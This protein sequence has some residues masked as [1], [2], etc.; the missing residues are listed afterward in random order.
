[1]MA[2][3][4]CSWCQQQKPETEFYSISKLAGTLRG[5]CKPCMRIIKTLHR[6]PKWVPPCARCGIKLASRTTSGRR[7]CHKCLS[8]AYGDEI[9]PNGAHRQK[10]SK[11]TRCGRQKTIRFRL[12]RLCEKCSPWRAGTPD[13][14]LARDLWQKYGLTIAQY[15]KMLDIGKGCCWICGHPPRKRRLAVEHDH[16]PSKRV[17]GLVCHVCNKLRI[18]VNTAETARKILVYLES[19][20]DGRLL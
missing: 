5:Q 11:C 18:G 3:K 8:A 10:L 4:T 1:M 13:I 9:R 19:D 2:L 14:E 7:L 20:F 16:G 12:G 17:R 6:D 15:E